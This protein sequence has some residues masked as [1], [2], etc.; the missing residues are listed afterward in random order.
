MN[1]IIIFDKIKPA[2]H[3]KCK[4]NKKQSNIAAFLSEI[5][6][7]SFQFKALLLDTKNLG[8]QTIPN[9]EIFEIFTGN[10]NFHKQLFMTKIYKIIN[11]S[12]KRTNNYSMGKYQ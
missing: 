5:G 11:K 9:Y 8:D 10:L 12:P 6:D 7:I 2:I 1:P 4:Y 3:L